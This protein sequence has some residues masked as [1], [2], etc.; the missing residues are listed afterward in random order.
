MARRRP[1]TGR[2]QLPLLAPVRHLLCQPGGRAHPALHPATRKW[3]SGVMSTINELRLCSVLEGATGAGSVCSGP[4]S[5]GSRERSVRDLS[6]QADGAAS[7]YSR[8]TTARGYGAH[9][10]IIQCACQWSA[11]PRDASLCSRVSCCHRS[12]ART[13]RT[14]MH[15]V[16]SRDPELAWPQLAPYRSLALCNRPDSLQGRRPRSN[17]TIVVSSF[18]FV[19]LQGWIKQYL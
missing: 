4:R 2:L 6:W 12:R 10:C 9:L 17:L 1:G 19:S 16:V 13:H 7:P 11:L 8:S 14:R 3:E 5:R 18:L 15:M